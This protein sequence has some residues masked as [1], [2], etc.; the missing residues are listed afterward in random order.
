[1]GKLLQ[2]RSGAERDREALERCRSDYGEWERRRH[3][4]QCEVEGLHE[5]AQSARQAAERLA[6]AERIRDETKAHLG[7]LRQ[8]LGAVEGEIS[9]SASLLADRPAKAEQ[10]RAVAEEASLYEELCAAFGRRGVQAL[11]ID[12]ALPELME[13][14]NRLLH[15]M[16]AGR[17]SLFIT[18]QRATQKGELA[19]TLD[20]QIAD[21]LG[22]RAYEMYS[23]GEAF[24]IDF[25]LRIA[26]SRLLARRAGAPLP[27]LVVDEGF[28]SQDATGRERL[29]EAITA[30]QDE[31]RM[32]LAITHIDELRD[33]FPHRIHVTK[34]PHGSQ[35]EVL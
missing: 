15:R 24:R 25:A 32:I 11:L 30:V 21:E 10:L 1:H 35:L 33:V 31:F 19:E 26:L 27:I 34:T 5:A 16:T 13:E 2:A 28:G 22:T 3:E 7:R 18:T 8:A 20:I 4:A 29:V 23:G 14:A 17:M 9:K 12:S 6:D